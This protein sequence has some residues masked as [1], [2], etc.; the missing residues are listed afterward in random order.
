[1]CVE[2]SISCKMNFISVFM[3]FGERNE[4]VAQKGK[5]KIISNTSYPGNGKFKKPPEAKLKTKVSERK[6]QALR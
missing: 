5:T 1:M 4:R 6:Q 3:V 2:K